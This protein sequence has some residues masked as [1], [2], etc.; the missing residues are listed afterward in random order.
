MIARRVLAILGKEP[1]RHG[2]KPTAPVQRKGTCHATPVSCRA[3]GGLVLDARCRAGFLA[4]RWSGGPSSVGEGHDRH[5]YMLFRRGNLHSSDNCVGAEPVGNVIVDHV[6]TRWGVDEKVYLY[7][8]MVKHPGGK[9]ET[10]PVENH[11]VQWCISSEAL[12]L[13]NHAF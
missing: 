10:V 12:D 9:E 7:R 8:H 5:R 13:N 11:T 3:W 4:G 1:I 6:S 2:Q